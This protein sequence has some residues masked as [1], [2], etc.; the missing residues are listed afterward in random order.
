MGREQLAWQTHIAPVPQPN[1]QHIPGQATLQPRP[2]EPLGPTPDPVYHPV[3]APGANTTN[4]AGVMAPPRTKYDGTPACH[5]CQRTLFQHERIVDGCNYRNAG[6]WSVGCTRCRRVGVVCVVNGTPITRN[7]DV[8][9]VSTYHGRSVDRGFYQC[10]NCHEKSGG[11]YGN[12]DRLRPCLSCQR[13]KDVCRD[14]RGTRNGLFL[15]PVPG[16]DMDVYYS[17]MGWGPGGP[18]DPRP[19]QP[20]IQPGPNHHLEWLITHPNDPN[21]V[22]IQGPPPGAHPN[23]TSGKYWFYPTEQLT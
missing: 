22:P 3:L 2:G 10:L 13:H 9:T 6:T 15:H 17:T 21:T 23:Q 5:A 16:T 12:C 8:E 19:D 7:V 20:V 11:N 14:P 18:T 1:A 4:S